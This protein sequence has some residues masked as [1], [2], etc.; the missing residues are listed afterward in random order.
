M[1]GVFSKNTGRNCPMPFLT[2]KK[3]ECMRWN[4][5]LIMDILW[6]ERS[7]I[8]Q[9]KYSLWIICSAP[10]SLI[11]SPLPHTHVHCILCKCTLCHKTLAGWVMGKL[12]GEYFQNLK[13][14]VA[15]V[16]WHW[17]TLPLHFIGM[18][19]FNWF[20]IS[21]TKNMHYFSLH[22]WDNWGFEQETFS[23]ILWM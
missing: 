3:C 23:Q 15:N 21:K 22:I 16:L 17:C 6:A 20:L 19:I 9:R 1:F 14:K 12:K 10:I 5:N 13:V 4:C 18:K 7:K 8:N 2:A 11:Y